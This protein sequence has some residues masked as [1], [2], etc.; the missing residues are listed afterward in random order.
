MAINKIVNSGIIILAAGESSRLGSPKQLLLFNKKYLLQHIIDISADSLAENIVLVLG[1]FSLDIKKLI[2]FSNVQSIDNSN[3]QDGLSS[4][5]V[6][7]LNEMLKINPSVETIILVLCDQPYLSAY[8]LNE[9]FTK[10]I[11]TNAEIVN[12]NYGN[13]IG[14]PVLFYKSLFPKL[15]LLNGNEGAKSIIK[16]NF[17]KVSEVIFPEGNIDIDT[18][19]DY[20]KLKENNPE[21]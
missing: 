11:E 12:C 9:I 17:G 8:I 10:H 6:C 7:G 19:S 18:I 20:Q 16:Q 15:K 2:N 4:S 5:I 14:P 1:A 13:A 21:I 3:W